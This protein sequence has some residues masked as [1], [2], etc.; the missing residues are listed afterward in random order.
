[1]AWEKGYQRLV[2]DIK[3]LEF[4]TAEIRK[5]LKACASMVNVP[6]NT[7]YCENTISREMQQLGTEDG[8]G[9]S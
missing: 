1:M 8:S 5:L 6:S 9:A 7:V 3:D 4:Q 2:E